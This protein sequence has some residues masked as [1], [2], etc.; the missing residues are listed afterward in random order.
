VA[1]ARHPPLKSS[2]WG[3]ILDAIAL[4]KLVLTTGIVL[5]V[6]SIGLCARPA[7]TLLLLRNPKLGVRAMAS[8]FVLTPLFV[9][10]LAAAVQLGPADRAALM[11][12][13]ISPMPPLL[14]RRQAIAGGSGDYAVGL[15]VLAALVSIVVAPIVVW[16]AGRLFGVDTIFDPVALLRVLAITVGAPLAAGIL[17]ARLWPRAVVLST[18]VGRAAIVLLVASAAIV[19]F[20]EAPAIA[21]RVG[22]GI[23]PVTVAIV[24]FGLLVGHLL[25]GPDPGSRGALALATSTRHPGVAI[26]LATATFP[27]DQKAIVA[28]VLL[29]LIANVVL[30]LPYLLWRRHLARSGVPI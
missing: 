12:L 26:S 23:V 3:Y 4:V 29:F 2:A 6:L 22:N 8:M 14:P 25:G 1:R 24:L 30:T 5:T 20:K 9:T 18:V 27:L 16:L 7:D 17:I 13:S 11:A 15:S 28:T 19:L 21:G 10:G